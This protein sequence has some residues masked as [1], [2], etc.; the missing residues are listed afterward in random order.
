MTLCVLCN[1]QFEARTSYGLCPACWQR[2]RL[3]EFDRL[4][5]AKKFA[6]VSNLPVTL[7]LIE[8]LAI[9]SDFQGHCAYC[10]IGHYAIIEMV[11]RSKGLVRDNVVPACRS[12]DVFVRTSWDEAANRVISYV[13]NRNSLPFL[14]A[15]EEE[16]EILSQ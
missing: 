1:A 12:C 13:A 16:E 9:L 10:Q 11:D 7:T 8:W 3:R 4:E 2:D 5:S 6:R 15:L 14:F